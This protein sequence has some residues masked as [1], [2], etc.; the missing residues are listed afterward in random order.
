MLGPIWAANIALATVNMLVV[1]GVL[2]VYTRN[3]G[4][5]HSKLALGLIAFSSIL[6]IQ[7]VAAGVMYW[8][9]AQTYTAAVA[10]PI[11][12]ITALE[13]TGLLCLFWVTWR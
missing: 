3:F 1:A 4:A 10:L 13:T 11:L 8:Q 5:L 9:L 2:Y 6:V 7:N 12:V